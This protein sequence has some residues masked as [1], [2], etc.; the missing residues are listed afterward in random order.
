MPYFFCSDGKPNKTNGRC[1]EFL[2]CPVSQQNIILSWS[3]NY[4]QS[5]TQNQQ[6]M[7]SK[8]S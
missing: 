1:D 3:Q 7:Y 2:L 8:L 6:N 4:E 5:T